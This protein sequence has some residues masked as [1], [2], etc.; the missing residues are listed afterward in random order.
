MKIEACDLEQA[1]AVSREQ[2]L[3]GLF[4]GARGERLERYLIARSADRVG[5]GMLIRPDA[6]DSEILSRQ[7]GRAALAAR[8]PGVGPALVSA[9]IDLAREAGYACLLAQVDAQA[10]TPIWAFSGQ[11][12][13]L[14]DVG[15]EFAHDLRDLTPFSGGSA[16]T[17][18]D[19]TES[20]LEAV[21]ESC[22]TIFRGS[23][24]Y[25]DPFYPR[26][27]ADE[28]HRRWIQNCYH[29]RAQRFLVARIEGE[30]VGFIACL[31]DRPGGVGRIDLV[32][33]RPERRGRGVGRQ[34]VAAAL[35]WFSSRA[36]RVLVKTQLTNYV[37]ASLYEAA[38]FRLHG[39][40]LT[41]N[42]V[43]GEE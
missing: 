40:E 37:V 22:A 14:V 28:L 11:G 38:G 2:A 17:I 21:L 29:G 13:R 39:S 7:V 5:G 3:R 1:R 20:D 12:F 30:T 42:K 32:G 25:T 31:L 4:D 41:F 9:G 10:W 27:R 26:D 35:Q 23:R 19:A 33:V 36:E 15:V 8:E 24:F 16:T 43:L 34:L 6:F 18:G